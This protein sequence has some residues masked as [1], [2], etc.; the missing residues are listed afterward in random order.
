ML[1]ISIDI[2]SVVEEFN[3]LSLHSEEFSSYVVDRMTEDFMSSWESM[4]G[5][6]LKSTRRDYM[7]AMNVE[8]VS[9]KETIISLLPT[10]SRLPMMIEDGASSFD[11]KDGFSKSSKK[12]D[13]VDGGWYLT[14]P[15][16]FATSEA[17]AEST[18]FSQKM[19]K[20]I[21]KIAK[22]NNG[23]QIKLSQLP[24]QYRKL[25]TNKT[26]GY[27]HKS[28]IYE[29][30]KRLQASSS[31]KENRGNY[32][33]FR[34]VSDNSEEGAW[35]HPGFQPKKFMDRASEQMIQNLTTILDQAT[36]DFILSL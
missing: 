5:R 20:P 25:L 17:L 15:F 3:I 23:E 36:N 29:G 8:K 6:E 12:T 11:M 1:P 30:I 14:I 24:D 26:S 9:Y 22:E 2:S 33:S 19:P 4:V 7:R 10:E 34:R 28:P 13:K 16:R 35:T 32:I 31:E 21:E 18:I 27:E